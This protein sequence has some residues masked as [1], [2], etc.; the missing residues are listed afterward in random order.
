MPA[1]ESVTHCDARRDHVEE[2]EPVVAEGGLGMHDRAKFTVFYGLAQ[3]QHGR[4]KPAFMTNAKLHTG[5]LTCLDGTA[6]A[7][8]GQAKRLFTKHML[9]LA[10]NL[11]NLLLMQ[12]VGCCQ[13]HSINFIDCKWFSQIGPDRQTHV[14]DGLMITCCRLHYSGNTQPWMVFESGGDVLSPP[15]E[16]CDGDRERCGGVIHILSP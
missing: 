3:G 8:G 1:A 7:G 13:H 15:A 10:G 9:P 4:L 16:A 12:C 14:G 11:H 5:L 2:R 6:G